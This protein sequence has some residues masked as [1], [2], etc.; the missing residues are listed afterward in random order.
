MTR[1]TP[2]NCHQQAAL[3]FG[4]LDSAELL[5]DNAA[6]A[7]L[8]DYFAARESA[9][10]G[11]MRLLSAETPDMSASVAENNNQRIEGLREMEARLHMTV[12]DA[13]VTTRIERGRTTR[14]PDGTLSMY[15]YEWTFYD[16][17]DLSDGEGGLDV[18]GFG[19]W[20]ILTMSE[21]PDG[22]FE[23]LSDEYDESDLFGINTFSAEHIEEIKAHGVAEADFGGVPD[24][25]LP[26]SPS[27]ITPITT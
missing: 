9:Y 3:R 12:L 11:E 24:S 27:A 13:D 25:A 1:L 26:C 10:R 19:T 14:N 2:L 23:I 20:H 5:G 8:S 21:R 7:A 18:A 6:E 17:D 4:A 16:Y 22:S 15:V